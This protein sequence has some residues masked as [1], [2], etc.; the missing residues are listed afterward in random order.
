MPAPVYLKQ[1]YDQKTWVISFPDGRTV[2]TGYAPA[3]VAATAW[4]SKHGGLVIAQSHT[5]Q[6]VRALEFTRPDGEGD[7][8]QRREIDPSLINL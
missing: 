6:T 4:A 2:C 5:G 8:Y 7:G 3:L 1:S